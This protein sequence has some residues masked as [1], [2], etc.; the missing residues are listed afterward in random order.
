MS[1]VWKM[2]A[3]LEWRVIGKKEA[4]ARWDDWLLE[5]KDAHVR[6]CNA[7]AE[8][9]EGSWAPVYTALFN[10]QKPLAMG[11]MLV[12][13]APVAAGTF[14]WINGGPVFRKDRPEGQDL[15][16]LRG[17]LEGLKEHLRGRPLTALRVLSHSPMNIEAQIVFRQAGFQRPIAPLGTSL[18]YL[19]DLTRP[20]EDLHKGL[21][22]NWRNQ[23]R[24][25]EKNDPVFEMGRGVE[26]LERYLP[27]HNDMC[28][29]KNLTPQI[30]TLSSLKRTAD[31]LGDHISFFIVSAQGQD[32]CGGAVWT[33]GTKAYMAFSAANEWGRKHYLPNLM[34][35]KTIE[36]LKERGIKT[37]DVTGID[38]KDGWSVY[39]FKRGLKAAPVEYL[40]EWDWA[41]SDWSRRVFNLALW[42]MRSRLS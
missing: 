39:N 11:L 33:F 3:G 18:T 1:P 7:W 8:H 5:F 30:Q 35:W 28:R 22:K 23:L 14:A 40:G 38:P 19:V 34:Y 21:E 20:L 2:P 32:G 12:R 42:G 37:L 15:A 6:Q 29:R 4:D 26:I 31:I 36:T 16:A 27:I 13:Q 41:A 24:S 9:K 10:G 25:S 17:Y